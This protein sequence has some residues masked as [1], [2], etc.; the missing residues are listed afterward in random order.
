[1]QCVWALIRPVHLWP[2]PIHAVANQSRRD[3]H[4]I[5]LIRPPAIHSSCEVF[6]VRV[7]VAASL[8][9][10][11]SSEFAAITRRA[12]KLIGQ[13]YR[14]KHNF[15]IIFVKLI[16]NFFGIRKDTGIPCER[17]VFCIPSGWTESGA[18]VDESVTG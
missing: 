3:V 2:L 4:G 16:E 1:M 9:F 11:K 15:E 17:S 8:L 18:Q 5:T 12:A 13:N 14:V 7:P 10:I 6:A